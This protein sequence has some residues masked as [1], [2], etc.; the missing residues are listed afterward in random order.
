[1][2]GIGRVS[3]MRSMN[4]AEYSQPF[5]CGRPGPLGHLRVVEMAGLG[6]V[7]FAGMLL[8]D[9]GAD[10]VRVRR[11][12]H[13]DVEAGATLRGRSEVFLDLRGESGR[14]AA[15]GLIQSADVLLEGFRPGVME[16]LGVGPDLALA[17]NPRLVYGRMTG[18]GQDGP[19]ARSAGHDIDYI[20]ITGALH[21]IGDD[22]PVVPL[23]LIGDYGGGALFL[24]TG[25][26]AAVLHA[27][28]SG[29]GQV[30]DCSICEGTVSL[31]SL[32][33]G[34]LQ[35]GRW[36]D[37]R[38]DNTLDGAAPYYRTYRCRDGKHVAVGAIEPPF[39][40]SLIKG[41]G[42]E[43][44]LFDSQHDRALWPLQA[45]ALE[46]VFATRSRDEWDEIFRETEA[47]VSPVRS[48]A[49]SG[50]DPHLQARGAFVKVGTE[51]QPAPAPRFLGTPSAARPTRGRT[52]SEV[53]SN[54]RQPAG[55]R[56]PPAQPRH[57]GGNP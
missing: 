37:V 38:H 57:E 45:R 21:A 39:F 24:A 8:A 1:M 4:G 53:L 41:L 5:E 3:N 31:L 49:E 47:C 30:V 40:R 26:L 28:T 14:E 10:V 22:D 36:R 55:G 2:H 50:N 17:R 16:R 19:R 18:W 27:R 9:M 13:A 25:V 29:E 6:P 54:W 12:G 7:T 52:A 51:T 56:P 35:A 46:D 32:M 11:P 34:L 15:W 20:A 42:L 43:S 23:N 48:L 44:A 33:H